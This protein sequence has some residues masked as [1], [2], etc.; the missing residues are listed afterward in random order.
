MKYQVNEQ[1]KEIA[2]FSNLDDAND[3]VDYLVSLRRYAHVTQIPDSDAASCK[4]RYERTLLALYRNID[5]DSQKQLLAEARTL[6]QNSPLGWC[7]IMVE[8]VD[9]VSVMDSDDQMGTYLTLDGERI[10]EGDVIQIA[11]L[12]HPNGL[13][14]KVAY[15]NPKDH[16]ANGWYFESAP[17]IAPEG[18]FA[19][20]M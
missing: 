15:G 17:G 3:L 5:E 13:T 4:N 19:R 7:Q 1:N 6:A 12:E 16:P 8:K 9:Y 18:V 2:V 20:W 11:S 10:K 14:T